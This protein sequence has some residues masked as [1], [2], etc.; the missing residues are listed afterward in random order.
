MGDL[1]TSVCHR[2]AYKQHNLWRFVTENDKI[3][4]I[5]ALN[6]NLTIAVAALDYKNSPFCN[7]CTIRELCLG[8]CLG[9]MFETNGDPFMVIPT[10]CAVE[11][12]KVAAI[13]DEL[14]ELDLHHH[15]IEWAENKK[16]SLKAY[17]KYFEGRK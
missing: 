13:L 5:E 2:A 16:T 3:T 11:H 4:D 15:F 6:Y 17:Y 12:A 14:K 9:S 10:V 1:T 8:Q 7:Y